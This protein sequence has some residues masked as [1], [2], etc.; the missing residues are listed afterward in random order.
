[1]S[2]GVALSAKM[3]RLKDLEVGFCATFLIGIPEKLNARRANQQET[4][5]Y[6][7]GF[8]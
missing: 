2:E 7:E 1:M 8:S 5:Q 6:Q 3:T 4:Q